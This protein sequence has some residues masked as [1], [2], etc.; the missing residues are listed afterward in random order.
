MLYQYAMDHTIIVLQIII[1]FNKSNYCHRHPKASLTIS[2][3]HK[4][5]FDWIKL[6][7]I[8]SNQEYGKNMNIC[9]GNS[10]S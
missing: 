10:S 5:Q 3:I 9:Q 4:Q 2:Y 6:N 1:A 7:H 8:Y